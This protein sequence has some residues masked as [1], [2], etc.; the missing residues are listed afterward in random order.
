[1]QA[2]K[3]TANASSAIQE[4]TNH[5][6]VHSGMRMSVMPLARKSRV[7]AMKFSAPRS[8]ATQKIAIETPHRLPPHPTP[9]PASLPAALSG[10]YSVQPAIGGPSGMKNASI[11]TTHAANVVQ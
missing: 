3:S 2:G 9:G 5:A 1:M 10:V 7:V 11:N 8:D 6:Q 4:V